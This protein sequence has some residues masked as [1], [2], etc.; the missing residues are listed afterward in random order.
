VRR[1]GR[2]SGR[3]D[4][5]R[6]PVADGRRGDCAIADVRRLGH[7]GA[8]R[9]LHARCSRDRDPGA[10]RHVHACLD[11]EFHAGPDG[12]AHAGPDVQADPQAHAQAHAEVHGETDRTPS[13]VTVALAAAGF[14]FDP[15]ALNVPARTAFRIAFSNE[16]VGIPHSV[17]IRTATGSQVF[18]GAIVTGAAKVTYAV[19]A[20]PAGSY[21]LF[22]TVHST[23]T[24]SLTV[25]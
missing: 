16:D 1:S 17:G 4:P 10:D 2:V 20:L 7:A 24:G 19:A 13:A 22:C 8:D 23:M 5:C 11:A 14:A 6:A 12:R 9:R 3:G 21:T 15:G 18:S 25:E